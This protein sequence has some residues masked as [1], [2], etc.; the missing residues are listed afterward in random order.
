M[1]QFRIGRPEVRTFRFSGTRNLAL[2][3]AGFMITIVGGSLLVHA[4][5]WVYALDWK[6]SFR[7]VIQLG[8]VS[9]LCLGAVLLP[10]VFGLFL[11]IWLPIRCAVIITYSALIVRNPFRTYR[12][13]Y[14]S[15]D[16]RLIVPHNSS[17]NP[18]EWQQLGMKNALWIVSEGERIQALA[19]RSHGR[20][21]RRD[22]HKRRALASSLAQAYP[23]W[24][25]EEIPSD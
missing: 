17:G 1:S 18:K 8:I 24:E 12:F 15:A 21:G 9:F 2:P 22:D 5:S 14:P 16:V 11:M 23:S 25:I 13:E 20:M 3:F 10:T 6:L 4:A 19:T 7:G